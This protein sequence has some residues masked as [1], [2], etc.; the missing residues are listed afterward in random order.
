[1]AKVANRLDSDK[2]VGTRKKISTA[3]KKKKPKDPPGKIKLA[4]ALR[5]LLEE[6]D[7]N[8]ITTAEIANTAG[9]NE[10]LIYR[11]FGDKRGL[12]HQILAE[13]MEDFEKKT[14]GYT[15]DID[16]PLERL[17]QLIL[18]TMAH[19][20]HNRVFGRILF[21]EARNFA[22]YFQSETYNLVKNFSRL[23][24]EIIQEGVTRGEIRDDIPPTCIRDTILGSIEH[25]ILPIVLFNKNV[26][27]ENRTKML[28]EILFSGIA[29]K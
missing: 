28:C 21:V 22:G 25:I 7:F 6:K 24:V 15:K 29:R 18:D 23:M 2:K 19:Y 8:S 16:S 27:T 26:D 11:Y 3:P 1:M 5:H 17:K 9:T 20:D 10:A 13:Y 14:V 4:D 12:L